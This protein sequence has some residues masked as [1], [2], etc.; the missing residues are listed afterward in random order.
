MASTCILVLGVPRSG[1]SCVAGVLHKIGVDM[2]A[3]HF[4]PRDKFN[5]RGYYE[6]LRWRYANQRITGRGYSL[7]AA[8]VQGVGKAQRMIYR[9][10]ARECKAKPLWG[11]KDPWL[12]FLG[13][14]LWP[15]LHDTGI[16]T[17]MIV[18]DRDRAASV[19]SVARHL[20]QSY[21]NKGNAERIIDAWQEGLERQIETYSGP[22]YRVQYEALVGDPLPTVQALATWVFNGVDMSCGSIE[23]AAQWVTPRLKHF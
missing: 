2:G 23:L 3:G 21:H 1:T 15:I 12:C 9:K 10:L 14:F 22:L 16:H 5:P 11:I 20:K 4:Q 6:D 17:K 8:N 7:K 18:I 13:Q 19:A